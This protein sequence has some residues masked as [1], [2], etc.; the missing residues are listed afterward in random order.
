M[1]KKLAALGYAA[2]ACK[3]FNDIYLPRFGKSKTG[4]TCGHWITKTA[5]FAQEVLCAL[6][7]LNPGLVTMVCFKKMP[8]DEVMQG[9]RHTGFHF[10]VLPVNPYI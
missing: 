9:L 1:G 5:I 3:T 6:R 10:D 8:S 4:V 2:V 7:L